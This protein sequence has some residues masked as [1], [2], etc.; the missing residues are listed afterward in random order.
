MMYLIFSILSVFLSETDTVFVDFS[1]V[2]G[3]FNDFGINITLFDSFMIHQK[4]HV[5]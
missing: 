2:S 3:G 4:L 5:T 1:N